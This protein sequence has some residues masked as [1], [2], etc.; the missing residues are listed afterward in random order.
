MGDKKG[1]ENMARERWG[2]E[3]LIIKE[4]KWMIIKSD[5]GVTVERRWSGRKALE[6]RVQENITETELYI[7][8]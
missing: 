7:T 3:R 1:D 6:F 2:D 8:Q 4:S 5:G